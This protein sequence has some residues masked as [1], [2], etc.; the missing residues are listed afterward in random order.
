LNRSELW[1]HSKLI[2]EKGSS[3][4]GVDARSGSE[5]E[6]RGNGAQADFGERLTR[7]FLIGRN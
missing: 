6:I 1:Q 2:R 3:A 4:G 7:D 5:W